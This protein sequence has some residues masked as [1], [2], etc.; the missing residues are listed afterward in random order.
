MTLGIILLMTG[1]YSTEIADSGDVN[2]DKIYQKYYV[3][4][5]AE[6]IE[7][8]A[9]AIFRFGGIK[10]TTLQLSD[11]S[12]IT[13]NGETTRGEKEFLQGMVY[14]FEN[15]SPK[16][17][18]YNF[19]FTDTD[20][21]KIKNTITLSSIKPITPDGKIPNKIE[22][23]IKWEGTAVG[24]NESV[25]VNIKDSNGF[26]YSTSTDMK[27]AES[28]VVS[29]DSLNAGIANLQ[30]I[31]RFNKNLDEFTNAGGKMEGAYYSEI[32][33]IKIAE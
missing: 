27:G 21:K 18:T 17:S 32:I 25:Q 13:V 1:C 22:S 31:R 16:T 7:S 3:E 15:L 26:T 11:G 10:G 20:N 28:I 33:P 30:L 23:E 2:Q 6:S 24:S 8:F 29:P 19:I 4:Y 9:T 14:R 5:D 12:T